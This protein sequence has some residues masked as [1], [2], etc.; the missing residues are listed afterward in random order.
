MGLQTHVMNVDG[1]PS[2]KDML[3][4]LTEATDWVSAK[5]GLRN[6]RLQLE[7]EEKAIVDFRMQ[8]TNELSKIETEWTD[9]Q[10]KRGDVRLTE[11]AAHAHKSV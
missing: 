10:K 11:F 6:L 7:Q 3:D 9:I 1:L 8:K 2:L 5:Y 4:K